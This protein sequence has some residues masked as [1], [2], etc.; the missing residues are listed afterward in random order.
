MKFEELLD[1]VREVGKAGLSDFE[2]R[3]GNLFIK[4]SAAKTGD[5]VVANGDE[6]PDYNVETNTR[7]SKEP[8]LKKEVIES[9]LEG[10]FYF[11]TLDGSSCVVNTGDHICCG[12]VLGTLKSRGKTFEVTSNWDGEVIDKYIEDGEELVAGEP[13]FR[14]KVPMV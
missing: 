1:L 7:I 14:L 11:T 6:L 8:T 13:M 3:E 10:I 4:M 9:P 5:K 12:Q 2:Y